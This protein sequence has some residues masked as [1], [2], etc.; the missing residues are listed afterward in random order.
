MPGPAAAT[1]NVGW[2]VGAAGGLASRPV[3]GFGPQA[4]T[5]ALRL[6]GSGSGGLLERLDWLP[7]DLACPFQP[8]GL[9]G[10]ADQAVAQWDE[11]D[12]KFASLQKV[13]E[14]VL[15]HVVPLAKNQQAGGLLL[16]SNALAAMSTWSV[17]MAEARAACA[18]GSDGGFVGWW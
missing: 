15:K 14:G 13:V 7:S 17:R 18:L 2:A 16:S 6:S 9:A 10:G 3:P 4:A 8:P 12:A 5:A 1:G 11:L